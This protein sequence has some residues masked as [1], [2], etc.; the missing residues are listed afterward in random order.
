[1]RWIL[2]GCPRREELATLSGDFREFTSAGYW[3]DTISNLLVYDLSEIVLSYLFMARTK[4]KVVTLPYVRMS[5][6]SC[7]RMS[8]SH[9]L[10]LISTQWPNY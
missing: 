3:F 6:V 2:A 9:L 1:M 5:E 10:S 4:K 7:V 8:S